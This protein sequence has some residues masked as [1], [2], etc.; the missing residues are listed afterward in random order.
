[1]TEEDK[2]TSMSVDLD[3]LKALLNKDVHDKYK[4]LLKSYMLTPV[5]WGLL[6]DIGS[7]YEIY[8]DPEIDEATF[9]VW[10][11]ITKYPGW[12]TEKHSVYTTIFDT[13]FDGSEVKGPVLEAVARHRILET[14]ATAIKG[15]D[16]TLLN[17]LQADLA[18]YNK[19]ESGIRINSKSVEEIVTESI[20]YGGIKWRLEDLNRSAGPISKGD[21][22]IVGKRPE[23]G[24]T[25]FMLSEFTHM[26]SQLP[27]GKH[28]LIVNNE[29]ADRK[30]IIRLV[31]AALGVPAS[32]V[33]GDPSKYNSEYLKFL[34]T[35]RIDVLSDGAVSIHDVERYLNTGDYG[36]I[37]LNVLEKLDGVSRKLEDYQ[38]L[39]KL[40]QWARR[41]SLIHGPV[42][43]IVQADVSA[44]GVKYPDQ[45]ML[46]KTKTGLQGEADLLIMIGRTPDPTQEHLRYIHAA[47]NK[48]PGDIKTDPRLRHIR[49][50]VAFDIETG[51]FT[52]LSWK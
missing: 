5:G 36:L 45:S 49:S 39:E 1:M 9:R 32:N 4:D 10:F 50:E 46:Y 14:M 2:Y 35:K 38:R 16:I 17:E 29:E 28:A 12:K 48:L 24:G 7:Y 26:V 15:N 43:A 52:S 6:G 41:M 13:L 11:R 19:I 51:R 8:K 23:T 37:G 20:R 30:I 40:G 21:L 18:Q 33:Y 3:I 44:E 25:S 27:E 47:K 31:C 42:M 34:G 22:V